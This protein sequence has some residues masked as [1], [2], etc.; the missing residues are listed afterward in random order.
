MA[1]NEPG[2]SGRD[3]WNPPPG[4]G[5]RDGEGGALGV[6]AGDDRGEIVETELEGGGEETAGRSIC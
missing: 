5:K 2:N 3:P 4:G 6:H 1:W